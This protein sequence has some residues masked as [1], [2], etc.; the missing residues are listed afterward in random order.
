MVRNM[1]IPE[2]R[3]VS[4]LWGLRLS[5]N[6]ELEAVPAFLGTLFSWLSRGHPQELGDNARAPA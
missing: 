3:G 4:Q 5:H 1:K 6:Q 2:T